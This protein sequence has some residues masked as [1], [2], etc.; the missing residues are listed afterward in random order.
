MLRKHDR[1]GPFGKVSVNAVNR[2]RGAIRLANPGK[3]YLHETLIWKPEYNIVSSDRTSD[4]LQFHAQ[5]GM[6]VGKLQS[7]FLPQLRC[8]RIADYLPWQ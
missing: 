2:P 7:Q 3:V 5:K 6:V 1:L 4:S 8:I